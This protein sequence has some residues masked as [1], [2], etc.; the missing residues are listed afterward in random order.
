MSINCLVIGPRKILEMSIQEHM[1]DLI[2]AKFVILANDMFHKAV[3]RI[4]K[5]TGKTDND[6]IYF[7][8][9]DWLTKEIKRL[10][11]N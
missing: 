1:P 11:K 9:N 5:R 3:E 8:W 2:E 10:K 7:E 4:I 6:L